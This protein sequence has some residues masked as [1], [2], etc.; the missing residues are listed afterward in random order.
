MRVC[1]TCRHRSPVPPELVDLVVLMARHYPRV[2]YCGRLQ[3]VKVYDPSSPAKVFDCELYEPS[4][5]AQ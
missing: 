3:A 5:E 4:G 2:F 1:E